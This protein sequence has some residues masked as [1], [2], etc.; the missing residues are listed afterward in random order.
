M[1][2]HYK[3]RKDLSIEHEGKKTLP[4]RSNKGEE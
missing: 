2:R 1:K 3:I 4:N